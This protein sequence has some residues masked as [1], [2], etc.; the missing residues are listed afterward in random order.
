MIHKSF[1]LFW[2]QK[3]KNNQ[4]AVYKPHCLDM[5]YYR[6]NYWPE[7][8]SIAITKIE[9]SYGFIQVWLIL[10]QY[11]VLE[12]K[13]FKNLLKY[14]HYCLPLKR[15]YSTKFKPFHPRMLCA[16][17]QLKLARWFCG[18]RRKCKKTPFQ[19][20]CSAPSLV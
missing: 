16:K 3:M 1:P 9:Q 8:Q 12:K 15:L 18:R 20:G 7:I 17:V 6:P 19:I 5:L 10:T 13:T 2:P 11:K 14:F 4:M